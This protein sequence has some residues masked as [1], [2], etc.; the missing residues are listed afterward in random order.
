MD[1]SVN[2][3]PLRRLSFLIAFLIA[4]LPLVGCGDKEEEEK[5]ADYGDYGYKVAMDI[6]QNHSFRAPY[7]DDAKA[8]ADYIEEQFR[9]LG[10]KPERDEFQVDKEGGPVDSSNIVVK[11]P[12]T[13]FFVPD[14]PDEDTKW[15]TVAEKQ[16][17]E[18]EKKDRPRKVM[19]RGVI[20]G[21]HY[22][23]PLGE[24]DREANPDYNGISDNASGVGALLQLAK[25]I[26]DKSF[27]YDITLVAFGAGNDD[28]AG[29]RHFAEQMSDEDAGLTDCV[30]VLGPIFAGDKLYAHSGRNSLEK[31][32]KYERRRKLYETTDVVLENDLPGVNDIDLLFN[33]GTERVE[34]P[35]ESGKTHIYREFTLRNSDYVPFDERNIPIVYIES[36][37]YDVDKA[38]K[39]TDS[40]RP[41]FES[42]E[43]KISGTDFDSI[44]TL[45]NILGLSQLQTRINNIAFILQGCIEKGIYDTERVPAGGVGTMV[46]IPEVVTRR[47]GGI[48][49]NGDEITEE[50]VTPASEGEGGEGAEGGESQ[51]VATPQ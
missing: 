16:K 15:L 47:D 38:D 42:T 11:I 31:G 48:D 43:G 30:Y 10:Y 12:G 39:V 21:A 26:K 35:P 49:A 27:G 44:E 45:S 28:F 51:P 37:N 8:T 50:S 41:S 6:A 46:T 13:G 24:S 14:I 32:H 17:R 4:I 40:L 25:I 19:K 18:E 1:R 36:A 3:W 23:T 5:I 22:D 2:K 34:W 9:S 29:A 7:S 33:E 20:I